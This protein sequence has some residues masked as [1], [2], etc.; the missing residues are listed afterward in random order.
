MVWPMRPTQQD[1]AL[2]CHGIQL[3]IRNLSIHFSRFM[4]KQICHLLAI[5][6][7]LHM[8]LKAQ[9]MRWRPNSECHDAESHRSSSIQS[10]PKTSGQDSGQRRLRVARQT[11]IQLSRGLGRAEAFAIESGPVEAADAGLAFG[12]HVAGSGDP[13]HA[14]LG[15]LGGDDPDCRRLLD[16]PSHCVSPGPDLREPECSQDY[17]SS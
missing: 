7:S 13:A 6:R 14:G 11:W 3:T 17:C 4:L 15:L 9:K 8:I 1:G 10:S 16:Q 2:A 12:E 5:Q